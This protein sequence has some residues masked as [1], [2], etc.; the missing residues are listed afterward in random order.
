ML[1]NLLIAD[2][3]PICSMALK[4]A[5]LSVDS[6]LVVVTVDSLKGA[7]T[8]LRNGDYAAIILDLALVDSQGLSNVSLIRSAHPKL[9]ILVVSGNDAAPIPQRVAALGAKGFLSKSAP[10]P[11]MKSAVSVVLEGGSY[12]PGLANGDAQEPGVLA[13]L[14]PAQTKVTVELARGSSN[15]V[16]AHDLGLSEATVKSHL[17]AI[18]RVLGVS[19]RSQAI[20]ALQQSSANVI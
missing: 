19:N 18:F 14:S 2:D 1:R 11:A 10:I 15:K 8:E 6:A 3:H 5:A 4:E 17:S 7:Q 12:F 20:L 16:I 9:P 13:Q